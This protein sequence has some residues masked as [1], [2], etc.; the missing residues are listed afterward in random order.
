MIVQHV[1]AGWKLEENEPP[2]GGTLSSVVIST[3]STHKLKSP[4][5]P[6]GDGRLRVYCVWRSETLPRTIW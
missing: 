6:A 3:P 4:K 1:S 2:R 5:K